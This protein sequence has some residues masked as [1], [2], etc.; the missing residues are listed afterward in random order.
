LVIID[1]VLTNST[2]S[3]Y[4]GYKVCGMWMGETDEG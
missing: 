2:L 1:D 3:L 4:V